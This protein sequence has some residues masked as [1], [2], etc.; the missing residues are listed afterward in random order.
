M[1]GTGGPGNSHACA[2]GQQLFDYLQADD[3]DAAIQA[4]LMEYHP[5]AAC[6]AIK[7]ACIIDAQ[8]RLASAW[9][10]RDRYLARQARLARRAAER[11]LKR[12]AMAPAHARQPLPAAAAAILARAKAKAAAGKGTP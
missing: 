10:A 11:D 5:C 9:A 2:R 7:R 12:A 6:D 4:G 8:Q 1:S 3:V